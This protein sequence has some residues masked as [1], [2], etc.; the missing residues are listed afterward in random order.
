[1]TATCV[2]PSATST[3]RQASDTNLS[4]TGWGGCGGPPATGSALG[5]CGFAGV[6]DDVAERPGAPLAAHL[7]VDF[8]EPG[9]DEGVDGHGLEM[10]VANPA[11]LAQAGRGR[12]EPHVQDAAVSHALQHVSLLST[13]PHD[14]TLIDASPCPPDGK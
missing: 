10:D 11:G 12:L 2:S 5:Q 1:M 8:H 6:T 13:E 7:V 4:W 3:T 9:R 14:G